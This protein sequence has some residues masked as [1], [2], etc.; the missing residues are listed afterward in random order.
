MVLLKNDNVLPAKKGQKVAVIGQS[1]DNIG[2]LLGNYNGPICVDG[3]Y[4]CF[5][6]IYH[7]IVRINGGSVTLE[8]DL[9]TTKAA[10]AARDAEFVVIVVDNARDGGGEGHDRDTISLEAKQLAMAKAVLALK[11]PTVLVLVNGGIIA[12]DDLKDLSPAIL[13]TFMPGVHGGQAIA[14]TIFGDNNPGGKL[15]VTMYHSSIVDEVDFFNMSMVAGPGRSYK[16]Y[17]GT[18]IFPFGFGLS[19]T[20]FDMSV[21]LRDPIELDTQGSVS[22]D[23]TLSNTGKLAGDEVLFVYMT[24][25]TKVHVD[26]PMP[27]KSLVNFQ[28]IHLA[29]GEKQTVS[30]V[31]E[32][33]RLALVDSK[34]IKQ[35]LPGLYTIQVDRGHGEPLKFPV[36]VTG[37]DNILFELKP[38]WGGEESSTSVII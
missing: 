28:R 32:A 29:A 4:D 18:P 3:K 37:N 1:A 9:D 5:P 16:F 11:K 34:G 26:T 22:I 36:H 31:L 15:P 24:N 7:E 27:I 25:E 14:E 12:I 6:S 10:N 33:K 19:Y 38:W 13:E 21:D 30:L 20:T 35:V 23:V 8:T 2:A 17:Q